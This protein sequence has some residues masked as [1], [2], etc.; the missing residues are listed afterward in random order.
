[1]KYVLIIAILLLAVLATGA[2]CSGNEPNLSGD[3]PLFE[4]PPAEPT[5]EGQ[6]THERLCMTEDEFL[7]LPAGEVESQCPGASGD[8]LPNTA[9][10]IDVGMPEPPCA[11]E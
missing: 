7:A 3:P 6:L 8:G 4:T 9:C 1:M 10:I 5:A 2:Y 11:S